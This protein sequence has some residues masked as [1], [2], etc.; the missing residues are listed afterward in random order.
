MTHVSSHSNTLESVTRAGESPVENDA[1][2]VGWDPEYHE[3][4]EIL[5]EAGGT[6]LQGSTPQATDSEQVP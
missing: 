1:L 6:T 4:R 3:T 5:W 2:A